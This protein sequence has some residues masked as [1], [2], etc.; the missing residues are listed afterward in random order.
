MEQK[1]KKICIQPC[2]LSFL[3][4]TPSTSFSYQYLYMTIQPGPM[5]PMSLKIEADAPPFRF[6]LVIPNW[7]GPKNPT[8]VL[9]ALLE[10][11]KP[12][13]YVNLSTLSHTEPPGVLVAPCLDRLVP[14]F[15]INLSTPTIQ[16]HLGTY[17][18]NNF[19]HEHHF[20]GF[21]YHHLQYMWTL[22]QCKVC[23][24][25]RAPWLCPWLCPSLQ[26]LGSL[27]SP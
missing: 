9:L 21:S 3:T 13:F 23:H 8:R 14:K 12:T 6:S 26:F 7:A 18:A 2:P 17:K 1:K 24:G 11:T 4:T 20:K 27:R 19:Q 10:R 5:W 15:L 25:W 16:H 22:E